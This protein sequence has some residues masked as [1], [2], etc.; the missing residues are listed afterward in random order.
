MITMSGFVKSLDRIRDSVK[1]GNMAAIHDLNKEASDF[2]PSSLRC[3]AMRKRQKLDAH[4]KRCLWRGSSSN[5]VDIYGF[6]A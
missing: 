1:L 4:Q 3:D 6:V 2:A 5:V